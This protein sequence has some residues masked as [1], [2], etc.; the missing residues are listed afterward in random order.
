MRAALNHLARDL[1]LGLA[2]IVAV[3]RVRAARIDGHAA[4]ML[5]LVT[6][7]IKV[8]GPL[9]DI[10]D[11]IVEAIAVRRVC[12]N[13]RGPLVAILKQVLPGNLPLAGVRHR[14]AI[15]LEHVP[16]GEL[17]ALESTTRGEFPL[18]LGGELFAGPSRVSHCV[19]IGNVDDRM[20]VESF[21]RT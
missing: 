12:A 20:I 17:L 16:P 1:A 3:L 7:Y 10:A 4:R 21:D 2:R 9:P 6:R 5:L 13:W 11:H 14:L 19:V 18:G 15:W 8:C